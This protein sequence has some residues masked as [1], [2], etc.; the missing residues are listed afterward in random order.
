M[1]NVVF[2]AKNALA[3]LI[4]TVLLHLYFDGVYLYSFLKVVDCMPRLIRFEFRTYLR[5]IVV[6]R[7]ES[8]CFA[9][10]VI[11]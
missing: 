2:G 3:R 7:S 4:L 9:R 8:I 11:D 5:L 10:F 1:H 6:Y